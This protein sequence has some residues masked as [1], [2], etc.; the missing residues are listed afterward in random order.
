MELVCLGLGIQ[1]LRGAASVTS[2]KDE[3]GKRRILETDNRAQ[4][5]TGMH[6]TLPNCKHINLHERFALANLD[7][8]PAQPAQTTQPAKPSKSAKPYSITTILYNRR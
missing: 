1:Q 2:L 4:A 5:L 8:R 6:D 7:R 3:Y